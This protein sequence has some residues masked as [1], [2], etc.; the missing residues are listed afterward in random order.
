MKNPFQLFRLRRASDTLPTDYE[1][2]L[3]TAYSQILKEG[4]LVIDIGAHSGR[5]TKPMANLVGEQGKV[6]AFEPNP[7]AVRLLRE[8]L[9]HEIEAGIVSIFPFALSNV[10]ELATFVIANERPEE[11]GLRQRIFNGPTSTTEIEVQVRTL[12]SVIADRP[13]GPSFMKIDVEGAE[14]DAIKG[15]HQTLLKFRPIIAFEFGENSYKVYD[16]RPDEVFDFLENMNYRTY[17]ILGNLLDKVS[18]VDAS[19]EQFFWD[20]IAS[21]AE[22]TKQV[23]Q[24]LM[25]AN[26]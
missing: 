25:L 16:V 13:D 4:D 23:E 9:S 15:A 26:S 20:Y 12:D 17:S 18:F 7:G 14:F 2:L 11:S 24:A 21:P 5:H 3:E 6:L 1:C 19:R 10:S 8:N 22:E